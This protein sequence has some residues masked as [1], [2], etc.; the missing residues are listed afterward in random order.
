KAIKLDRIR[1]RRGNAMRAVIT[2]FLTPGVLTAAPQAFDFSPGGNVGSHALIDAATGFG[3]EPGV[4]GRFSVRLVE[5]N[6]RV[7]L[8]YAKG[9]EPLVYAEQRRLLGRAPRSVIVNV[10][11]PDL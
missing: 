10:R 11:T 7:T 4:P 3:F 2:L 8:R 9:R 6:Y 1:E 5:G